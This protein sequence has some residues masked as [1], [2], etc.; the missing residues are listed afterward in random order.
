MTA[1]NQ[2][3]ANTY[4]VETPAYIISICF[5]IEDFVT[6]MTR[7]HRFG[8]VRYGKMKAF[9]SVAAAEA[10]YKSL[11]GVGSIIAADRAA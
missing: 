1:F 5:Q 11:R 9:P 4:E 2:I 10:A 3:D 7:K 6:V 8:G